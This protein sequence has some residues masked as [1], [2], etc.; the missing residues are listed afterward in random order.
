L[1]VDP[2]PVPPREQGGDQ[3][4]PPA[5]GGLRRWIPLSL[6]G[7]ARVGGER[8]QKAGSNT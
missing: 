4:L 5:G 3:S 6:W 2:T 1:S 7:R 8:L